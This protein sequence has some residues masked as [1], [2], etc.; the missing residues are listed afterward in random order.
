VD[1]PEHEKLKDIQPL[2]QKCGEFLEWLGEQG[3]QLCRFD[4]RHDACIPINDRY[5]DLLAS[6]FG[7][8]LVKLEREKEAILAEQR[9]LNERHSK[10]NG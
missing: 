7:I 2:S 1:L 4:S 9:A 3:I 10:A 5:V 8:D 6:F